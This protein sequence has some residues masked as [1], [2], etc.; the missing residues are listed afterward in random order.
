MTS[1]CGVDLALAF[2]E[3]PID[4]AMPTIV[5]I[6]TVIEV[7]FA[8]NTSLTP[9]FLIHPGAGL[10]IPYCHLG[11]N[12]ERPIYGISN[13]FIAQDIVFPSVAEAAKAYIAEIES[14]SYLPSGSRR[15]LLGGWSYGGAVA[16]EMAVQLTER[17]DT[18]EGII[19]IDTVHPTG[20]YNDVNFE[21]AASYDYSSA[22]RSIKGD[23][24]G[25]PSDVD[26]AMSN[27]LRTC[28]RHAESVLCRWTP[29]PIPSD[30][31]VHLIKAGKLGAFPRSIAPAIRM[32]RIKKHID[33]RNG[34][35]TTVIPNLEV[36]TVDCAHDD[37]F[38]APGLAMTQKAFDAVLAKFKS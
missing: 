24:S 1:C 22:D 25:R 23:A 4:P 10:A 37:M 19:L 33:K 30:I 14:G 34:W 17:G 16:L 35:D 13:T 8:E 7:T 29:R 21:D 28:Y 27:Y 6:P 31:P 18:V 12:A 32:A 36:D 3:P 11:G 26:E 38:T 20:I 9:L 2:A 15:W 5:D